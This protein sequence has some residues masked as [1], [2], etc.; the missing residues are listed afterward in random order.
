MTCRI[1]WS[2]LAILAAVGCCR[3]PGDRAAHDVQLDSIDAAGLDKAVEER[4][5]QVV[6]VD[7]WATWCGPCRELFP[8]AVELHK[9]FG[10]RGLA[11]ITVSLDDPDNRAA[12]SKFLD[13]NG[14]TLENY[15]AVYGV[16]PAAFTAFHIDDGAL[17]HLRLYD[18]QG[19]LRRA[20]QSGG[21]PLDSHEVEQAVVA[22]LGE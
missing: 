13:Q 1:L 3:E 8:H 9:R 11:V 16:G 22:A 7:F 10:D 19:K 17:P 2:A 5:G 4:R 20:F 14:P 18:R 6:L 12:V 21:K 15:L